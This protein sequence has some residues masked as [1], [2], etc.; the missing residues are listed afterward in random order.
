M[1]ASMVAW[2]NRYRLALVMGPAVWV[3]LALAA[4]IHAY[5]GGLPTLPLIL[6]YAEW[7]A[8]ILLLPVLVTVGASV[9]G[10][11]QASERPSRLTMGYVLALSVLAIDVVIRAL[12][13]IGWEPFFLG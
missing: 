10:V 7:C 13:G 1:S 4:W 8:A 2:L 12:S 6:T 3:V 5:M 11:Q 9:R